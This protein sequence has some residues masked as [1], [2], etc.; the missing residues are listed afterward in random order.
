LSIAALTKSGLSRDARWA[1]P[2]IAAF[3]RVRH[4]AY[5]VDVKLTILFASNDQHRHVPYGAQQRVLI[6]AREQNALHRE[7][8]GLGILGEND[9]DVV[10][11]FGL[12]GLGGVAGEGGLRQRYPPGRHDRIHARQKGQCGHLD[13]FRH[14]RQR[15]GT[16]DNDRGHQALGMPSRKNTGQHCAPAVA[17]EDA[18][19]DLQRVQDFNEAVRALTHSDVLAQR[20]RLSDPRAVNENDPVSGRIMLILE[21]PHRAGH[22]QARPKDHGR[23]VLV[24]T[25]MDRHDPKRS[26]DLTKF[27]RIDPALVGHRG[28]SYV[29]L[30]FPVRLNH[31]VFRRPN[32]Y[33]RCWRRSSA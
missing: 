21:A 2:G 8:D 19:L 32:C 30:I 27:E 15:C 24:S 25:D 26:V 3:N 18:F 9:I 33:Y 5:G 23:T 20:F 13:G 29:H 22:H 1:V 14:R 6:L 4:L 12:F 16:I 31:D 10:H 7:T 17:D 11:E 28:Q